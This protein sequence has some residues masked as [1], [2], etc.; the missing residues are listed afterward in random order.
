MKHGLTFSGFPARIE[1]AKKISK[2]NDPY[3]V[4]EDFLFPV[5]I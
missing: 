1:S 3:Y 4:S 5:M 2:G